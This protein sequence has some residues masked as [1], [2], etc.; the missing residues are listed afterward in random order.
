MWITSNEWPKNCKR[1]IPTHGRTY[2]KRNSSCKSLQCS[3]TGCTTWLFD[4]L[5]SLFFFSSS[6]TFLVS[7]SLAKLLLST[8]STLNTVWTVNREQLILFS[9]TMNY[10]IIKWI[11]ISIELFRSQVVKI[12]HNQHDSRLSARFSVFHPL[13]N[14]ILWFIWYFMGAS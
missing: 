4:S 6:F 11:C 5:F 8:V 2:Q 10:F 9:S 14:I 12:P 3:A 13:I 1:M 7:Y